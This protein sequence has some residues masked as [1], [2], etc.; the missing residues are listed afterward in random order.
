MK[1]QR[2]CIIG[3]GLSGLTSAIILNNLENVEVN[4]ISQR[5]KRNLDKRTTAISES[6]FK[7]LKDNIKSL[8]TNMFWPSKNIKLFYEIKEKK[9]NFLNLED[10]KNNLMYVYENQKYKN[11]LLKDLRN[12]KI[13]TINKKIN[14]LEDLKNY[15]LIILCY[16]C[17][18]K[19]YQKRL[20][21]NCN[22]WSY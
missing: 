14:N 2:I 6:N 17:K 11:I 22:Y 7:F 1:K 3:N 12:K 20:Q 4:L 19:I 10:K 8:N 5:S 21:R 18:E 16:G 15:D 9:I 13:K